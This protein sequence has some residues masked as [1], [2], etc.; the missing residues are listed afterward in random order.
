[1]RRIALFAAVLFAALLV[2]GA[3]LLGGRDR[4]D[5]LPVALPALLPTSSPTPT[6]EPAV[7]N[8]RIECAVR[9][10]ASGAA[11]ATPQTVEACT[12]SVR[13]VGP[14]PVASLD[15]WVDSVDASGRPFFS[16]R[17]H[18]ADSIAAGTVV[19]WRT[20]CEAQSG[21]ASHRV[22]FTDRS[23]APIRM[24]SPPP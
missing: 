23:G 8:V 2:A 9:P 10:A 22:H 6:P 19:D 17:A 24:A 16:C 5:L 12:G 13:V 7:A 11:Q 4:E 1:M 21:V 15:V 14:A 18:V 3:V 20:T